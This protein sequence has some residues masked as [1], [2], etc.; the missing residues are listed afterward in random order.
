[1]EQMGLGEGGCNVTQVVDCSS[2]HRNQ[3]M[4]AM[5]AIMA[6]LQQPPS[7]PFSFRDI[8]WWIELQHTPQHNS[9]TRT[10]RK[11]VYVAHV[12][13]VKVPHFPT[14]EENKRDVQCKFI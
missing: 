13:W 1:M 7:S 5:G 11:R 2:L 10:M 9:K 14:K 6:L 3:N 4:L 12:P 8:S